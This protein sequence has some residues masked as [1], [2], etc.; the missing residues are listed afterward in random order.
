MGRRGA[1]D[2]GSI[3]Y[4]SL[5]IAATAAVK[6]EDA[7]LGLEMS[8][9]IAHMRCSMECPLGKQRELGRRRFGA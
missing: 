4:V 5:P 9:S 3:D 1:V 6:V 7:G 8:T 2:V